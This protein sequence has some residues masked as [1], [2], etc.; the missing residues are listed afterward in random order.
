MD[1]AKHFRELHYSEQPLILANAWDVGSAKQLAAMGFKAIATSSAALADTQGYN[2][3][4]EIP[5][6]LL[7]EIAGRM[8]EELTI[9]FSVDFERGFSK[10]VD[11]ILKNIEQLCKI[12][13]AGINI[14]DSGSAGPNPM[15]AVEEFAPVIAAIRDFLA[16]KGLDLFINARTDAFLHKLPNALDETVMRVKA[17]EA[18]GADG[19][20]APY[21]SR[22]DDIK[23]VASACKI[24][25]NVLARPELPDVPT[26][27]RL[28]VRRVSM[29]SWLYRSL[30]AD[31][32]KKI[33][34]IKMD[35]SF[36]VLF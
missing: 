27:V 33:E 12:G 31:L 1:K 17:Y 32:K 16:R 36:S 14:E 18:A 3:G 5:L 19:V 34:R 28:G 22:E 7:L 4:E 25:L 23:A 15:R 29:G 13:V 35:Q 11:G 24:P 30:Q 8:K 20:F 21:I 10:D 9:P 2:D 26:L 6:H